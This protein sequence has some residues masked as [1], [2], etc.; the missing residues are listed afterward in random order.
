MQGSASDNETELT[1]LFPASFL[2]GISMQECVKRPWENVK[3]L[4]THKVNMEGS[5]KL[6]SFCSQ[7]LN[8]GNQEWSP[9]TGRMKKPLKVKV[10][11]CTSVQ[12]FLIWW[13]ACCYCVRGQTLFLNFQLKLKDIILSLSLNWS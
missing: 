10:Q 3:Y 5:S 2:F 13:G 9:N 12:T 1:H 11:R 8:S 4:F 6:F 7:F